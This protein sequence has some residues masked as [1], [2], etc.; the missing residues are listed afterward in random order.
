M[1]LLFPL[2]ELLGFFLNLQTRVMQLHLTINGKLVDSVQIEQ[3]RRRDPEYLENK[4]MFLRFR[5]QQRLNQS[6]T[7]GE[8]YLDPVQESSNSLQ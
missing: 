5:N 2:Y 4:K 3:Q 1:R 8:F 6:Q 7:D